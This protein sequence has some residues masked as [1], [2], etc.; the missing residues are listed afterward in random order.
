VRAL[1]EEVFHC[2]L[3]VPTLWTF[4]AVDLLEFRQVSIK[5]QY[6]VQ[7]WARVA[8]AFRCFDTS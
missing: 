4:R 7:S 8:A 1:Q 3:F 5:P 6:L 2:L